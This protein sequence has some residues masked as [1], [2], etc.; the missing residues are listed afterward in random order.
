MMPPASEIAIR[1]SHADRE[2]RERDGG[3]PDV[4]QPLELRGAASAADE[5]DALVGAHVAD[6]E[7]RREHESCSR[8]TSSRSVGWRTGAGLA[9]RDR[10]PRSAEDT[11]T[12]SPCR[13]ATRAAWRHG[14]PLARSDGQNAAGV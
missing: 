6:A 2:H 14:K 11:S 7:H 1:S 12:T 13:P 10:V 5:V 3:P 9:Q 8:L 4:T